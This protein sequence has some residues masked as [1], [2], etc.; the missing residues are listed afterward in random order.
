[1]ACVAQRPPSYLTNSTLVRPS[2]PSSPHDAGSK[3]LLCSAVQFSPLDDRLASFPSCH[4]LVAWTY[5]WLVCPGTLLEAGK[6]VERS[7][8]GGRHGKEEEGPCTT[9]VQDFYL[10]FHVVMYDLIINVNTRTTYLREKP[11]HQDVMKVTLR[12]NIGLRHQE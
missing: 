7:A 1:M 3:C 11:F 6:W 12:S 4:E 10:T 9:S 5:P 2:Q 8:V